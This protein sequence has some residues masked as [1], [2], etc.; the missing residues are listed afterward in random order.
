VHI[1]QRFPA[2]LERLAIVV[3][4]VGGTTLMSPQIAS[5]QEM[6]ADGETYIAGTGGAVAAGQPIAITVGG[7]PH[8]SRTPRVVAL[9]LAAGIVLVGIWASGRR[10]E[11]AATT[12]AADRKR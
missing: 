4:R 6:P 8:Q 2:N 10:G 9:A 3:K 11:N 5:Q 1:V 7:V 12:Q